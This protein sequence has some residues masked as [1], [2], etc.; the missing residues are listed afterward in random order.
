MDTSA[1][2]EA[3][4]QRLAKE[5]AELKSRVEFL[6][7]RSGTIAEE[8]E[9][10]QEGGLEAPVLAGLPAS[11]TLAPAAANYMPILG[12]A[13]LGLAGA[14]I[15]RAVTESGNV[16]ASI[17]VAIGV[18]YAAW[19]LFTAARTSAENRVAACTYGFTAVLVLYPMLWETTVRFGVLPAWVTACILGAFSMLGLAI[20]WRREDSPVT[21]ISTLAALA[22]TVGLLIGTRDLLPFTLVLL[23]IAASI[24]FSAYRDH[25]LGVRWAVAVITDLFILLTMFLVT[26]P[27]GLPEGYAAVQPSWV[28]AIL[29]VLLTV[30]LS[31]TVARTLFR[32][33]RVTPFE[34]VQNAVALAM[35][36]AGVMRTDN[37]TGAAHTAV[38]LLLLLG[39]VGCYLVAFSFLDSRTGHDR[40]FYTYATFGMLLVMAGMR[41]LLGGDASTVAWSALAVAASWMGSR[42]G[43]DTLHYH[44]VAYL[45]FA[46]AGSGLVVFPGVQLL[47]AAGNGATVDPIL[48]VP[49]AAGALCYLLFTRDALVAEPHGLDE[50]RGVFFLAAS[51]WG[52]AGLLHWALLAALMRSGLGASPSI[53]AVIGTFLL[54]GSAC[55]LAWASRH[56]GRRELGWLVFPVIILCGYKILT[57]DM[58]ESRVYAVSISLLLYGAALLGAP[59]L[60]RRTIRPE[61]AGHPASS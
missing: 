4:L 60:L 3:R 22:T 42:A 30:Y 23:V 31:S 18:V 1:D 39:G 7:G 9:A 2:V 28:L 53:A 15:L 61:E 51:L 36:I 17:G 12:R 33:L 58:P 10:A 6:E 46:L 16:A 26:R 37:G 5:V 55:A 34:I 29:G 38:A 52:A 35:L 8:R 14:Y 48:L 56:W 49:V 24:E 43:R 54:S 13:L 11:G 59:K 47:T 57:V 20:A 27:E 45:A 25:W 41:L 44:G 19:W 32:H 21:W 50:A 40:N